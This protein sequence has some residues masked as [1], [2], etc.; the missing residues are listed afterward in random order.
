M[1][2]QDRWFLQISYDSREVFIDKVRGCDGGYQYVL[3]DNTL[4]GVLTNIRV[5]DT[6]ALAAE[7]GVKRINNYC[8][9]LKADLLKELAERSA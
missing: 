4:G 9:N 2:I 5:Y 6:K 1:E 8:D 3:E 7:E